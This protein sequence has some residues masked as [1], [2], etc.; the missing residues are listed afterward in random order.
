MQIVKS[1]LDKLFDEIELASK[2]N[3]GSTQL[4]RV[5]KNL[6][7]KREDLQLT[8]SFKIRGAY[9]SISR[10]KK[11][12]LKDGIL[13]A[14][15]GNHAQ[16]VAY[17]SKKLGIKATIVMPV[18][19]PTI[20]ISAVKKYGADVILF[21]NNYSEAS[22]YSKKIAKETKQVYIHPFDDYLVMAGQGVIAKEILEELPNCKYIF[23][24]VGGGGLL[25]GILAYVKTINKDIVVVAV[26]PEDSACLNIALKN[27]R[28][29]T[30][31]HVGIFADGVAVKR[32]G[33]KTFSI[34]KDLIDVSI[35]V[36]TDQICAAIADIYDLTRTVVEGS[37]AL[38]VAGYNKLSKDSN[39]NLNNLET[40]CILSGANLSFEKLQFIAER[41]LIGS[42]RELLLNIELKEEAGSLKNL[43]NKCLSG[44]NIT[45]FSYRKNDSKKAQILIGLTPN[46][47]KAHQRLLEKLDK[48]EYSFTNLSNNEVAK[49]HL[50]HM[51]SGH[52]KDRSKIEEFFNFNFPEKIGALSEFLEII[53]DINISLFNYRGL[54]GDTA[55]ILIGLEYDLDKTNH[56]KEILNNLTKKGFSFKRI[57]DQTKSLID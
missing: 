44:I 55:N 37:G 6:Y 5:N 24:P 26:E 40:V 50:R 53:N 14:S 41:N 15:A 51:L 36:S 21:G 16:G 54:G 13:T 57:D 30:L 8:H 32:I 47:E 31:E 18:T 11:D 29:T 43:V 19:T 49:E 4:F 35:T 34:I 27:G 48:N 10:I 25:A 28:P 56:F 12:K 46:N 9:N 17:A 1:N 7:L 20:K 2:S 22:D 23:V 42:G 45:Q 33:T 3:I 52:S 38:A 39:L